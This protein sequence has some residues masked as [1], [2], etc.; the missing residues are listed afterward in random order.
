LAEAQQKRQHRYAKTFKT[1]EASHEYMFQRKCFMSS[2]GLRALILMFE[3]ASTVFMLALALSGRSVVVSTGERVQIRHRA[4]HGRFDR[5]EASLLRTK[6]QRSRQG[7][8]T[9]PS[10]EWK[11]EAPSSSESLANSVY[12]GRLLARYAAVTSSCVYFGIWRMHRSH[13]QLA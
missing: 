5:H 1:S 8:W 9:S 12:W 6:A 3:T 7:C 11:A 2:A 10:G 13:R 4:S